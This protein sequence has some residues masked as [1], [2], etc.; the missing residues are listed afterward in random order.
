MNDRQLLIS[1][2]LW[3]DCSLT[4]FAM[5]LTG[6]VLLKATAVINGTSQSFRLMQQIIGVV[7][8]PILLPFQH[9]CAPDETLFLANVFLCLYLLLFEN[10]MKDKQCWR[11][12][13]VFEAL[14]YK[15]KG[16]G[17]DSR[18]CNWNSSLTSSFR[19]PYGPGV[20]LA[21]N[22]NEHQDYFLGV[23]AAG[24]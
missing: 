4:S 5:Q 8:H 6:V 19:P 20:D 10:Y 12:H 9:V 21:S 13:A 22:W 1:W 24:A 16:R 11:G 7:A 14:R 17:I 18:W 23:K 3:L 2:G 15:P